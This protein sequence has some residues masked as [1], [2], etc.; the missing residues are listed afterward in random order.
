MME[1]SPMKSEHF[2]Q[3][4][5]DLDD[6]L[7]VL[8]G[9]VGTRRILYAKRGTFSGARL[10]GELL[11]G[12]GDWMLQRRDGVAELVSHFR[13]QLSGLARSFSLQ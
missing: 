7:V 1:M 9:P 3:M 10:R 8:D 13:V 6:P 5:A 11:P 12:G 2:M 4:S